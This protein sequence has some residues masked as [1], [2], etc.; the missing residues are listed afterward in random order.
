MVVAQSWGTCSDW[1]EFRESQEPMRKWR[2]GKRIALLS[3][4][5]LPC[6]QSPDRVPPWDKMAEPLSSSSVPRRIFPLIRSINSVVLVISLSQMA[7]AVP[8]LLVSV[9]RRSG[10]LGIP[11]QL[12]T[13][14]GRLQ[15]AVMSFELN[16]TW[17][18]SPSPRPIPPSWLHPTPPPTFPLPPSF[19]PSLCPFPLCPPSCIPPSPVSESLSLG[20]IR[21]TVDP[22][23]SKSVF[24]LFMGISWP[25]VS[26]GTSGVPCLPSSVLGLS[27]IDVAGTC[28]INS[29]TVW[30]LSVKQFR[31]VLELPFDDRC[32]FL[33]LRLEWRR[34]SWK[35]RWA[36]SNGMEVI[37][38]SQYEGG[39]G[40][41]MNSDCQWVR[42]PPGSVK[43]RRCRSRWRNEL[44]LQV[45][46]NA[47]TNKRAQVRDPTTATR[48]TRLELPV[49]RTLKLM[50]IQLLKNVRWTYEVYLE[51]ILDI[52]NN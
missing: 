15:Q 3:L 25:S 19:G 40:R 7:L 23:L 47:M 51:S 18:W 46:P 8:R 5:L 16:W 29:A 34:R 22:C 36:S 14:D 20:R 13:G 9:N 41:R 4:A 21:A 44:S 49:K 24:V 1:L 12:F 38:A 48:I 52:L 45:K 50:K 27:V 43:R 35:I 37:I 10:S 2:L 32:R 31:D 28:S 26:R 39:A 33:L 30:L 42:G 6:R 17:S 11:P